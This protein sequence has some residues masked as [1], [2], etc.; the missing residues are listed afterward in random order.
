MATREEIITRDWQQITDGKMTV[1]IQFN[2]SLE[3][4]DSQQK[5]ADNAASF[6]F[7]TTFR[8]QNIAVSP[9]TVCWVRA[10]NEDVILTIL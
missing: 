8:Y 2:G 9:P 3:C 5:P 4:C 7:W 1:C 10:L 6:K